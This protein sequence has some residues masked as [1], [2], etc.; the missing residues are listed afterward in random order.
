M[1]TSDHAAALLNAVHVPNDAGEHDVAWDGWEQAH[2][3]WCERLDAYRQTPEGQERIADL[4]RRVELAEGLVRTAE[5]PAGVTCELCGT[6]GSLHRTPARAPWY[7]TL[8]PACAERAGY[9]PAA[10][11]HGAA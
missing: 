6:P 1:N 8:C 7:K 11:A 10:E 9:V 4:D 3:A 2:E 5:A